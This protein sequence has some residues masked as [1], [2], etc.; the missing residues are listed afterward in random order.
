[1][2]IMEG[3]Q[4]FEDAPHVL[5]RYRD[6]EVVTCTGQKFIITDESLPPGPGCNIGGVIGRSTSLGRRGLGI[7]KMTK[8]QAERVRI[9]NK[10][11]THVKKTESAASG[12]KVSYV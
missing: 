1:M 12:S 11:R 3:V 5:E 2:K 6:G 9:S 7:K 10:E 4:Q 8:E